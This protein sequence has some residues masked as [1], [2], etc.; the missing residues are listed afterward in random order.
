[1]VVALLPGA[2]WL[3]PA[4]ASPAPA[5]QESSPLPP[6]FDPVQAGL[7]P[8]PLTIEGLGLQF[9]LPAGSRVLADRQV[10]TIQEGTD[11]PRWSVRVRRINAVQAAPGVDPAE[12]QIDNNLRRL[13]AAGLAYRVLDNQAVN[14]RGHVG[15]LA[16]IE[17]VAPDEQRYVSGLLYI[18]TGASV[19]GSPTLLEFSVLTLPDHLP[20][21]KPLLERSFATLT[22]R[23]LIDVESQRQARLAA[24]LELVE[25]LGESRLRE[26]VGLNR[27]Y[28]LYHPAD[29]TTGT[30]EQEIGYSLIEVTEAKKGELNPSRAPDRYTTAEH[31][32]GLLVRVQGRVVIDP[33]TSSYYDS[34]GLYWVAWDMSS[35][36]WSILVTHRVGDN[37]KSE[38]ET[39]VRNATSAG[40]PISRLTV[41]RSDAKSFSRRPFEWN[42]PRVYLSQALI[43]VIGRLLPRDAVVEQELAYYSYRGS[44][45]DPSVALRI[46]TWGPATD[47]SA[48]WHLTTRQHGD[49]SATLSRYDTR[50]NLLRRTR[51]DGSVTEPVSPDALRR[52]WQRKGLR[53]SGRR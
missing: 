11:A 3:A 47:G 29:P 39:G 43:W 48:E 6:G 35:E 18:S 33:A 1:M 52:L 16:F 31:E 9:H 21:V 42:V 4:A 46:D 7:N 51:P 2:A 37:E 30:E 12:A 20:D 32:T 19:T 10:V 24:G 13:D 27:W 8:E 28:R 15:R 40:E 5:P 23:P 22:V 45:S 38:S 36:A 26:L 25:S 34:Q 44:G 53:V 14:Y 49:D 41:V 17:Q 50:G